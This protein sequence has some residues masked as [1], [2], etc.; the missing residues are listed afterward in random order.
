MPSLRSRCWA[1]VALATLAGVP[2]HL[3]A[4]EPVTVTGHVTADAGVPLVGSTVSIGTMGVGSITRDDGLYTFIVPSNRVNGQVVTLTARRVGYTPQSA[5]ITLTAGA[6][7]TR[8]FRLAASALQLDQVIVTGAGTSQVRERIGTVINTVDSTQLTRATT[9]QN[10]ISALAAT[11]PNVQVNTQ[12]GEPGASAF[13]LIRGASS[14]TGTNQPL[15]V[16]DNQP[17]DNQTTSTSGG[18]GGTVSQNRAADINPNDVESI[19]I[20]KGAASSAIYGARAANGVILITTKHGSS[21]PTRYSLTST[22]TFDDIVKTMPLQTDFGQGS[23]G[24]AP[25]CAAPDCNLTSLSWGPQLAAG[26]PVYQHGKEIYQTGLTADN[27]LSVSGGNN[28]TTFYLSGGQTNQEGVAKGG[29]N[30]YNRSTVRLSATHQLLNAL[31]FGGNFS[32]IGT[33]GNFVQKG[34]N[35]SGLLLG[36]LRTSPNFNNLP[37][38][39][40]I[41]GLHRSYRFPRPDAQSVTSGRGYD[42]PFFVLA[43]PANKSELGRF[44]GHITGAWVP[45]AWLSVNET[46]GADNYSDSRLQAL[47][48][49]SSSDPIGDVTRLTI[50]NLEIDHN[51]IAT[52]SHTFNTNFDGRLVLGQNLNSRR[53][54]SVNVFG[55]QLIA[56]TPYALQNT[57]SATSGEFKSLAHIEAYFTQA[58]LDLYN[59]LHLTAGLRDDGFSTFGASKRT[60]LY[61]KVDAAW[62]FT[63]ALGNTN[64]T[65]LLSYGKLRAAYGETGREPPVYAATSALSS[66]S[67]FGSGFG[68]FIGTKQSGQGGLVFGGTLGN[69]NLRPERNRETEFGTDLGFFNQ[70]AD[71]GF[72]YYNKHSTEVILSVP[73]NTSSTGAGSELEN[74]ATVTNHGVEGN[75]TIRALQSRNV[76]FS[77]GG[78]YAQNN[79]RVNS[80]I[81]GVH[82]IGY[83][84]GFSG[85]YGSSTVGYAPGVVRG[86]DFVRCGYGEQVDL[87]GSGTLQSVD[88]A[89]GAGAHKGALYIAAN[90]QPVVNPDEMVIADPNPRWTAGGNSQLRLGHLQFS[91]LFDIRHGGH[92]WDGTRAALYRFGTHKDTDVR[93]Q[94]GTFGKNVDVAAYPYVAGPGA[95]TVAFKTQSDWQTWF[96]NQGGVVSD[97]QAQFVESTDYVKWRELSVSYTLEQPWVHSRLGLGSAAIRLAGRNLHTWTKYRGLDPEAQLGGAEFL[98]QGFDYFNNPLT[99]SFVIAVTLNR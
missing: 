75:V 45:T 65:G 92:M 74:G 10:V 47:P 98:T 85:S 68:D 38:L 63:N 21:G 93:T 80:L 82:F 4:Q 14:V 3:A 35:T 31:T 30:R 17:I 99:R 51:L 7:I 8:D 25:V 24:K 61:P 60:A 52:L 27:A 66:S 28:R 11:A 79:G 50:D 23:R 2:A 70:R 33:T 97:A 55:E 13:I 46:F 53:Y 77:V 19:Q 29:N 54:R 20:L 76:D 44:I 89:C 71:L 1:L 90:G 39:D 41:S 15:I 64:Q 40:P 43:N 62:I 57:V 81:Q 56:P 22:E 94:Q 67:T 83:G 9:P 42:N 73:V 87:N 49:T 12:S 96:T 59:Q 84:E 37:Y 78:V 36:A 26:T 32:Y 58:E 91:T 95:G 34:S 69:N 72:T 6:T 18:D 48:L 88:G 5:Q 16:V 86:Q